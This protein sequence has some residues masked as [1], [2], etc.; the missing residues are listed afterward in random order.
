MTLSVIDTEDHLDI[1]NAD[2]QLGRYMF[3]IALY[4]NIQQ[5]RPCFLAADRVLPAVWSRQVYRGSYCR[6]LRYE[7]L[8]EG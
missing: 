5:A 1:D 4:F 8:Q 7:G 3:N 2:N 6:E